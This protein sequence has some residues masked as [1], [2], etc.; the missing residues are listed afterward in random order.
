[1]HK[2]ISKEKF[3]TKIRS[4]LKK[5]GKI[6]ALSHGVFDLVHP[7]YVIHL[8]QAKSMADI[9]IIEAQYVRKGSGHH[10]LIMK[11]V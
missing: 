11:C 4:E 7:G 8:E 1:M 3:K 9:S 2:L 5:L 10:I 6:V